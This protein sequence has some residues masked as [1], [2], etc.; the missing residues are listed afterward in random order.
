MRVT[1]ASFISVTAPGAPSALTRVDPRGVTT[2]SA[3]NSLLTRILPVIPVS[4]SGRSAI[5]AGGGWVAGAACGAR[6][7]PQPATSIVAATN[8]TN[9]AL[10]GQQSGMRASAID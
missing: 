2:G 10:P 1:S 3:P 7:P 5:N 4:G 8:A 6:L 9:G